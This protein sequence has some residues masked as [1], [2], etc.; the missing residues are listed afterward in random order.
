MIAINLETPL[1]KI[2]EWVTNISSPQS[3]KI[4]SIIDNNIN[5]FCREES[6]ENNEI[7]ES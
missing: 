4:K 1:S 6:D 5:I 3:I 7:F 2:V